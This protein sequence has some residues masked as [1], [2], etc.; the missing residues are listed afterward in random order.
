M[1]NV[2]VN[3]DDKK[4]QSDQADNQDTTAKF[5]N[6]KFIKGHDIRYH[7]EYERGH[8]P[9]CE[10]IG[11]V[12]CK[13]SRKHDEGCGC[14]ICIIYKN[15]NYYF[16]KLMKLLKNLEGGCEDDK[17]S[18][19]NRLNVNGKRY[20]KTYYEENGYP[21][22]LELL[23]DCITKINRFK[24]TYRY[25]QLAQQKKY[26]NENQ[27][28]VDSWSEN[29]YTKVDFFEQAQDYFNDIMTQRE[30]MAEIVKTTRSEAKKKVLAFKLQTKNMR[31]ASS[32]SNASF[33]N[34]LENFVDNFDE[35]Q[36]NYEK[37]H[38]IL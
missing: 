32:T 6:I 38:F 20:Y 29:A 37:C 13:E 12:A 21:D 7:P 8:K 33:N 17:Y 28:D 26:R 27:E 24:K 2:S 10:C 9:E 16:E 4:P 34:K 35:I 36:R 5:G 1:K 19:R 15:K 22:N 30:N 23:R 31:E 18:W 14:K 25:V 11:C 3:K